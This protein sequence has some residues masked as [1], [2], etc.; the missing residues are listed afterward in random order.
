MNPRSFSDASLADGGNPSQIRRVQA[1]TLPHEW[2]TILFLGRQDMAW[3]PGKV[4]REQVGT[5]HGVPMR[6]K[7]TSRA[8]IHAP[9]GCITV[10]APRPIRQGARTGLTGIGYLDQANG[11]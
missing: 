9:L 11:N 3:F 7:T 6:C 1:T 2:V 10:Q 5:A 8:T 4:L